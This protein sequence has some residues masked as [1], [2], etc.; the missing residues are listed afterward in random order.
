MNASINPYLNRTA[1]KDSRNFF[2]RHKEIST[3]ISRVSADDPQSISII[4][5]RKIGKSS[6]LRAVLNQHESHL[7]RSDEYVFIYSDLQES[8]HG[9]ISGF[10]ASI[11]KDISLARLYPQIAE[12]PPTYEYFRK[13]IVDLDRNRIKL[14][15]LLDEFD[16]IT[17]NKNFGLEFFS[18]LR[19]LPNN[20]TVSYIITSAHD[21]LRYC[22]SQEIAGS[23]FFNIFHKMNLG[24]FPE[25][26]AMELISKP[27]RLSEYSLEPHA[28]FILGLA[29]RFPF[30][31]Q[32]ACCC[33][34]EYLENNPSGETPDRGKI[35][36]QFYE[37][38]RDHFEYLWHHLQK[39][40]QV[41]CLKLIRKQPF[42]K[43]DIIFL[44]S[45]KQRGYIEETDDG[46]NLFSGMFE[47]FLEETELQ[48]SSGS[49][50]G[51]GFL[52]D[53]SNRISEKNATEALDILGAQIG[54]FIVRSLLGAGAMGNVYLAE[55]TVLKRHIALKRI[56]PEY[57]ENPDYRK[58]FLKEAERASQLNDPHIAY[59]YDLLELQGELILVMEYIKGK[60]L[61][62]RLSEN[63][64]IP[65]FLHIARQCSDALA[66][67]H[68]NGIVHCDIKPANIMLTSSNQVKILDF[69]V[70]KVQPNILDA[71]S[72]TTVTAS[73]EILGCTPSYTAPE[74][75]LELKV[76]T[77]SDI[78]SL[79]IVFYEALGNRH[80]FLSATWAQTIDRIIHH[81]P[82]SLRSLNPEVMNQLEEIVN[83]C[84]QKIPDN[85]YQN[86][87]TLSEDLYSLDA[88][89]KNHIR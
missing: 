18:F 57:R 14:V 46:V 5:E 25:S 80:P 6:L 63:L 26:E 51:Y 86:A 85:R 11:M 22:H 73:T 77:R 31:L 62:Q 4:G 60:T 43:S 50:P 20:Y 39:R 2:G 40:E 42:D 35:Q 19:S 71:S 56:S 21:I 36:R 52:S 38:A 41:A 67:A 68:L 65:Q 66:S 82:T 81:T 34:Y 61:K 44:N 79:G 53:P 30:F 70:A 23:P 78:F 16:A 83:K 32:L 29:G 58:R 55:D 28:D 33:V 12:K 89:H 76:D 87:A 48:Q 47:T 7:R 9:D 17:Q 84:L 3:I 64:S 24:C 27:S 88:N 74:Y 15:L 75:L 1:I 8:L 13:L 37:E 59:I 45:L 10:F 69:G 54:R 49:T 72:A